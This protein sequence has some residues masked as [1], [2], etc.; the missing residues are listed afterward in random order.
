MI[1]MSAFT[2]TPPGV[3][4]FVRRA[5][6]ASMFLW[7][8][9]VVWEPASYM[10]V[11]FAFIIAVNLFEAAFRLCRES[12]GE[13]I[14]FVAR[15]VFFR[16][17][18]AILMCKIADVFVEIVSLETDTTAPGVALIMVCVMAA[19]GFTSGLYRLIEGAGRMAEHIVTASHKPINKT[20]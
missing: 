1:R 12:G 20:A 6:Y 11:F 13:S 5:L 19:V 7:A 16:L 10:P 9:P 15:F 3:R 2:P 17:C 8:A 4:D 14:F 18:S